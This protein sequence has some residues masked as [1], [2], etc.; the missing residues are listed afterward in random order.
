MKKGR[1][2]RVSSTSQKILRQLKEEYKN[3][4]L[5]IDVVS[6]SIPFK[7]RQ[8]GNEIINK[9]LNKEIDYLSVHSIDRLGR[10]LT[11]ILNTLDFLYKENVILKVDNLGIENIVDNKPNY[12]FKLIIAVMGSVAEMERE[13]I[14]ER[15][16]EGIEIAKLKGVY[17]GRVK[18]TKED[19]IKF[20]SRYKNVIKLLNQ[21]YSLRK[22]AKLCDISLSTV[23]KV[24]KIYQIETK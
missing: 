22:I 1:Y 7:E 24:N 9:I 14:L 8:K 20:L 23:Q 17:K 4:I 12:A 11:D 2:I 5:F 3:E 15:Q 16:R 18:G 19:N 6:G 13:T 10:N 21:K